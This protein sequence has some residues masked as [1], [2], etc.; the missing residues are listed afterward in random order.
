MNMTF[1]LVDVILMYSLRALAF[2]CLKNNLPK[3]DALYK[4]GSTIAELARQ[5]LNLTPAS[6]QTFVLLTL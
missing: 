4:S 3:C 1:I 2:F 6:L 5:Q